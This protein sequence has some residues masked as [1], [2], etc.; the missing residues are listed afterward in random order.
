MKFRFALALFALSICGAALAADDFWEKK[1]FAEWSENEAKRVLEDS[2]WS[3]KESITE[4]VISQT[5]RSGDAA[6]RE[7][8]KEM[9]YRAQFWS[10]LP[11]REARVRTMQI[12]GKYKDMSADQKKQFDENA[13]RFIEQPFPDTIVVRVTY[14]SNVDDYG[15][16]MGSYWQEQTTDLQKNQFFLVANNQRIPIAQL[17]LVQGGAREFYALFPRTVDGQPV[18]P[19][20]DGKLGIEFQHPDIAGSSSSTPAVL[21]GQSTGPTGVGSNSGQ[22]T[23]S[24]IKGGRNSQRIF[25]QF[26]PNKMLFHG[27]LT[28]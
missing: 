26:K 10:A 15:R 2:P 16:K 27:N 19:N 21:P 20:A 23:A 17:Q 12:Q 9:W 25:V 6:D 1:D 18:L 13:K 22:T 24:Q 28:Y 11:M 5:S 4:L 8:V 14:G 3:K 7:N